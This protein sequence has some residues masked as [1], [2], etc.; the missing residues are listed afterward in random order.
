MIYFFIPAVSF[1]IVYLLTPSIRYI[2]L[3]FYAIDRPDHR[4]LH[5]KVITKLGGLGIYLG[6]WG[7]IIIIALFDLKFFRANV[8]LV[9]GTWICSTL[10]FLLGMYDDFQGSNAQMKF[11]VQVVIALLLVKVG[12]RVEGAFFPGL[13]PVIPGCCE[14]PLTV[15][16]I[17][18]ITNAINLLDGLDGLASSMVAVMSVFFAVYGFIL[19]EPF[20]VFMALALLGANLGFLKFNFYPAKIFMGD[21][22]SLFMG[23]VIAVLSVSPSHHQ[24][25]SNPF[26]L[27]AMILL[28]IPL[29]DTALAIIR[30]TLRKQHIF[31]S[32]SCHI[33]HFFIKKGLSQPQTVKRFCFLTVL[34]GLASLAFFCTYCQRVTCGLAP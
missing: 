24:E 8:V 26:L 1:I 25:L 10:A 31:T 30:R 20:V 14:I 7:G 29:L 5:T 12:F 19:D 34:L 33:H 28:L 6:F 32:D 9:L 18:G 16:W 4:K 21:A 27:P 13:I 22:G 15:L 11:L 2:G 3:K 23:T 17:V